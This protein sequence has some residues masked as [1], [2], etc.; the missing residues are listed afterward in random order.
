LNADSVLNDDI[1]GNN[2]F[3]YC[4]NNPVSRTDD[5]SQGWWILAGAVIGGVVGGVT[6]AIT[7]VASGQE[8]NNGIIGAVVGGAVAG[9]IIAATGGAGAFSIIAA[10][11]GATSESVVNQ[12]LSYT[13]LAKVNGLQQVA[14]TKK[15]VVTSVKTV[16][17]DTVVNGTVAAVTGN[18]AGKVVPTNAGWFTPQKFVSSFT[19]KYAVK[20]ELQAVAQGSAQFVAESLMDS[21]MQRIKTGQS[22]VV[23]VF[24]GQEIISP[25]G[26]D[27][28]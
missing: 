8:W 19:G 6:K 25:R 5:S 18:I 9:A 24:P 28:Y 27:S 15:N 26:G 14:V 3:A 22:P 17:V 12:T 10:Y 23:T 4:G 11:S 7:N 21:F 13:S 2:L 20:V 1:L 16:A